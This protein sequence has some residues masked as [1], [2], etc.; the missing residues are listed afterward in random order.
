VQEIVKLENSSMLVFCWHCHTIEE[1]DQACRD[2][3]DGLLGIGE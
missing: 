2:G 3:E 1:A